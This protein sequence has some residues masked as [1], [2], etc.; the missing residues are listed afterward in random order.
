MAGVDCDPI[1]AR[2]GVDPG[3]FVLAGGVPSA[4]S[5]P[6]ADLIKKVNARSGLRL[7]TGAG[8]EFDVDRV[9][10]YGSVVH[11]L[12]T[13]GAWALVDLQGDGIADGYLNAGFLAD[14]ESAPALAPAVIGVLSGGL[15]APAPLAGP[16]AAHGDTTQ[17]LELSGPQWCTRFEGSEDPDDCI[18]PFRG[19][20]KAFLKALN[21]AGARV[22]V[23]ATFRPPERAHLMH[24]AWQI[25]NNAMDPRTVPAMAGVGIDWVHRDAS[26]KSDIPKSRS[27]AKQMVSTYGLVTLPALQSR[28]TERRA[29]DMSIAWDGALELKDAAGH[30]RNIASG[31]R[32]GMNPEVVDCGSSY[33]VIK[34]KFANDP[35]HWSDD[36][37]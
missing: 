14:A 37:H 28:H 5:V 35:P 32:T 13:Q 4:P 23:S 7:R 8:V 33:G 11:V 16:S 24:Y 36:G 20:L 19:G 34:A 15:S 1:M 27:L 3:D 6:V 18:D 21:D 31:P 17:H 2:E 25:A 26:G 30:A 9:L 29:A 10:P 12:R 22:H